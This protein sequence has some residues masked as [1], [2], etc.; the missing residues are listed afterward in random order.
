MD[1]TVTEHELSEYL[2]YAD[3]MR[4]AIISHTILLERNM[5]LFICRY[6]CPT[7]IKVFELMELLVSERVEFMKK[8]QT[9]VQILRK[10]C[11]KNGEDFNKTYPRISKDLQEICETRN[12]FAHKLLIT[13]IKSDIGKHVVILK[14]FKDDTEILSYT[15]QQ[16]DDY[17][18]KI[19]KY[20][21]MIKD[22]NNPKV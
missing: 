17:L 18:A 21:V 4:G 22:K 14:K 5:D 12:D 2:S 1:K 6:F 16:I 13:P 15:E 8:T 3:R 7:E 19:E 11:N 20:S 9:F 10:E